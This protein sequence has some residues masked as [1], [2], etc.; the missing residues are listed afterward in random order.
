VPANRNGNLAPVTPPVMM[1]RGMATV[2]TGKT[3]SAKDAAISP[4]SEAVIVARRL[5]GGLFHAGRPPV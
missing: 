2:R 3:D 4:R 1:Y 5:A